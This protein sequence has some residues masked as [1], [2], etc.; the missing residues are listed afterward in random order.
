MFERE[1]IDYNKEKEK[2]LSRFEKNKTKFLKRTQPRFPKDYPINWTAEE[3]VKYLREKIYWKNRNYLQCFGK[4]QQTYEKIW[5]FTNYTLYGNFFRRNK[6]YKNLWQGRNCLYH[7]KKR[8][9]ME[10]WK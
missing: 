2:E 1:D 8:Q 6:K 10:F 9:C 7:E 4:R 3:K 5:I